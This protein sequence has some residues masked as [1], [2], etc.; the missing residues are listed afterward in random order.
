MSIEKLEEILKKLPRF[1]CVDSKIITIIEA[2]NLLI[3]YDRS[4]YGII[5][6]LIAQKEDKINV[7]D[8]KEVKNINR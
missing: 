5:D 2:I 6:N 1:L 3:D 8:I 7:N 4:L